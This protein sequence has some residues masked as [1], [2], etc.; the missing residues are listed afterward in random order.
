MAYASQTNLVMTLPYDFLYHHVATSGASSLGHND[1]AEALTLS[2]SLLDELAHPIDIE[3]YLRN[4]DDVTPS[5]NASMERNPSRISPH[6][7]DDHNPVVGLGSG[8]EAVDGLGHHVYSRI[9]SKGDISGAEVV[10]DGFGNPHNWNAK[11]QKSYRDVE[12]SIPSDGDKGRKPELLEI[13]HSV[14]GAVFKIELLSLFCGITKGV[15]PI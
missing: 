15:G 1:D 7:L 9:K 5:G 8:V 11:S 14:S 13:P 4:E 12:G 10:I 6:N 3:G 2:A